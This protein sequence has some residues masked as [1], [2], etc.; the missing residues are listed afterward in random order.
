[1]AVDRELG[2]NIYVF[3]PQLLVFDIFAQKYVF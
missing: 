2:G 3:F 1:M